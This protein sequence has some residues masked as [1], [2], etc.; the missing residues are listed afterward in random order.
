MTACCL[1]SRRRD[2]RSASALDLSARTY[3]RRPYIIIKRR[4]EGASRRRVTV[5]NLEY[6]YYTLVFTGRLTFYVDEYSF[7]EKYKDT[8]CHFK[9][10]EQKGYMEI[11]SRDGINVEIPYCDFVECLKFII[12]PSPVYQNDTMDEL[13]D[14]LKLIHQASYFIVNL[15][16]PQISYFYDNV[17]KLLK[18]VRSFKKFAEARNIAIP[19][20]V[21]YNALVSWVWTYPLGEEASACYQRVIVRDTMEIFEGSRLEMFFFLVYACRVTEINLRRLKMDRALSRQEASIFSAC[22]IRTLVPP[23]HPMTC[24]HMLLFEVSAGENKRTQKKLWSH[25]EDIKNV[26]ER[27]E[28][29]T[30]TELSELRVQK[31]RLFFNGIQLSTPTLAE[32]TAIEGLDLSFSALTKFPEDLKEFVNLKRLNMTENRLAVLPNWLDRLAKLERLDISCNLFQTMADMKN[33]PKSLRYLDIS[34]NRLDKLPDFIGLL[35]NL[36]TFHLDNNQLQI[37]PKQILRL[38][39]LKR[40]CLD[41]N[42]LTA[43][44]DKIGELAQLTTLCLM[45]NKLTRL[46][47]TLTELKSLKILYLSGNSLLSLPKDFGKLQKLEILYLSQNSLLSLPDSITSLTKLYLLNISNNILT[48]LPSMLGCLESLQ[49]LYAHDNHLRTLPKSIGGL[50]K[51]RILKASENRINALPNEIGDLSSLEELYLSNNH[52]RAV[53]GTIENL[54]RL[55]IFTIMGN[56]LH[57]LPNAIGMLKLLQF[58]NVSSNRLRALP[59]TITDLTKLQYFQA[60][61]NVLESLPNGMDNMKALDRVHLRGNNLR[62]I[63]VEIID[64]P[65]IEYLDL[66]DN[67]LVEE[68]EVCGELGWIGMLETPRVKIILSDEYHQKHIMRQAESAL[69]TAVIYWSIHRLSKTIVSQAAYQPVSLSEILDI[70]TNVLANYVGEAESSMMGAYINNVY[71][72]VESASSSRSSPPYNAY[73]SIIRRLM[74]AVFLKMNEAVQEGDRIEDVRCYLSE[75]CKGLG[76]CPDR[77]VATFNMAYTFFYSGDDIFAFDRFVENAIAREKANLFDMLVASG[78]CP[79][80][81]HILNFWRHKLKDVLGFDIVYRSVWEDLGQNAFNGDA[82]AVLSAFFSKFTPEHVVQV[83]VDRI[84]EN[85]RMLCEA[86]IFLRDALAKMSPEHQRSLFGFEPGTEPEDLYI[87]GIKPEGVERIL[88]GMGFLIKKETSSEDGA[89]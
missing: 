76:M 59:V 46:P 35:E 88:L 56:H 19:R 11:Y 49:E 63:P 37:F 17:A 10:S 72:Q 43:V 41:D 79:Q 82:G 32:L 7:I 4:V 86:G 60:H 29:L 73:V 67:P 77:K 83:L 57:A 5:A 36:E 21:Y 40:L 9:H 58:L 55:R 75:L 78:E 13:E 87:T 48:E 2:A 70:W 3:S 1:P 22:R 15:N 8:I 31:V 25:L 80:N 44:P 23:S 42:K 20:R 69:S 54:T 18:R 47:G 64:H 34:K 66:R 89:Q 71:E 51:L 50:G 74:A 30:W 12:T 38:T 24:Y 53:P 6:I 26:S 85:G 39:N 27:G 52:I 62:T 68:G 16:S 61:D 14:I 65:S 33:F 84:N 28:E 81:V 45:N